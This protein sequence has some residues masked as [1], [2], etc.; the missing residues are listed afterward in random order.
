MRGSAVRLFTALAAVMV[1][2]AGPAVEQGG[3]A[4]PHRPWPFPS[5]VGALPHHPAP[6]CVPPKTPGGWPLTSWDADLLDPFLACSSTCEFLELQGR[7]DMVALMDRLGDWQAVRLGALGPLR[8]GTDAL[9]RKRAEFLVRA[10]H[11]Y[12]VARAEVFALY[13]I[14]SAFTEDLRAMLRG[15]ARQKRLSVTLGRMPAAREALKRRGINLADYPDREEWAGDALRGLGT[16]VGDL[17]NTSPGARGNIA[18]NY[19]AE[20]SQ[21]PTPYQAPL[22]RIEKAELENMLSPGSLALGTVD[23]VTFGIPLGFYGAAVGAGNGIYHLL[24]GRYEDAGRELTAALT[25]VV[26]YAGGKAYR[27]LAVDEGAARAAS[28]A[29]PDVG[30]EARSG[31]G[32]GGL[33]AL[34]AEWQALAARLVARLAT[35]GVRRMAMYLQE[36]DE[37]ALFVYEHGEVGAYA[38]FEAEGNVA[39]ARAL[40]MKAPPEPVP[41]VA[42]TG[43]G[44]AQ[45]PFVPEDAGELAAAEESAFAEAEAEHEGERLSSDLSVLERQRPTLGQ[46]SEGTPATNPLWGKYVR[47]VDKRI[48]TLAQEKQAPKPPAKPAKPPLKWTPYQVLQER[49]I[50][51]RTY[52]R[53]V[54][55]WVREQ[56]GLPKEQRVILREADE[57]LVG[58]EV[59]VSKGNGLPTRFVDVVAVEAHPPPGRPPR[60][61]TFSVKQRNLANLSGDELQG[62][63]EQDARAATQYYGGVIE[64]LRRAFKFKGQPVQVHQVHLIYDAQRKPTSREL[65]DRFEAAQRGAKASGVEVDFR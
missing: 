36:S 35:P 56:A 8:G 24:Q 58:A 48:Q 39:K 65:M 7:T 17:L 28:P 49:F 34:G 53:K 51:A 13:I 62:Q 29:P 16:G 21:L 15:L 64:L 40:M 5:P 63:V 54:A 46:A 33:P 60:V 41:A 42:S 38:L 11:D 25:F 44:G 55:D 14:H 59:G 47:Y 61:I 10:T 57:W 1:A 31:A 12:G 6:A 50:Q 26:L 43:A 30:A 37:A 32:F 18:A 9:D 22:D 19:Y 52:H 45:V 20:R 3:G 23:A 4:P 2:C 27:A